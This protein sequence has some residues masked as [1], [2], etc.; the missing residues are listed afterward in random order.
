MAH[1]IVMIPTSSV[2]MNI[3]AQL[4]EDPLN[5]TV[6]IHCEDFDDRLYNRGIIILKQTTP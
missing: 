2:L 6:H 5:H 1:I 4:K 3:D